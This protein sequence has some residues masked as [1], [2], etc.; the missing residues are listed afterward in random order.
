MIDSSYPKE[1]RTSTYWLQLF[2]WILACGAVAWNLYKLGGLVIRNPGFWWLA[3]IQ[4]PLQTSVL[5]FMYHMIQDFRLRIS[6]DGITLSMW[7]R[8]IYVEWKQVKRLEYAFFQKQLVIEEPVIEKRKAWWLW[9]DFHKLRSDDSFK[10]IPFSRWAWE[11]FDEVE[12]EVRK[13]L[14]HLLSEK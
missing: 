9:L 6:E 7:S 1:Y 5:V 8:T 14:P 13:F 11:K 10:L 4:V 3:V 2:L 12:T